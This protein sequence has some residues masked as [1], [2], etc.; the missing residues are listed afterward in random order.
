IVER[1][2]C[3]SPLRVGRLQSIEI[4][5][6]DPM[7]DMTFHSDVERL[8][9]VV[10]LEG[11]RLNVIHLPV[12]DGAVTRG[13]LAD[14]IAHEFAWIILGKFFARTVYRQ[15]RVA[16][17]TDGCALARGDVCLIEHLNEGNIFEQVHSRAGWLLFLQELW[18]RPAWP[19]SAFYD[20]QPHD[21]GAVVR[22]GTERLVIEISHELPDLV[23]QSDVPL[24]VRMGGV[25]LGWMTVPAVNRCQLRMRIIRAVGRDLYRVAVR[26]AL[27]G[28]PL[29]G[30]G[31]L[32]ARLQ[33]AADAG[34]CG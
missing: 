21:P 29:V 19:L 24:D 25:S 12:T 34:R 30:G 18:G 6:T 13:L 23:S 32:R 27:I 15:L 2:A 20:E 31:T 16:V 3:R 1:A 14:A 7:D 10:T 26:E 33:A 11:E 5:I 4:E 28:A 8:R 17:N 22:A 9:C